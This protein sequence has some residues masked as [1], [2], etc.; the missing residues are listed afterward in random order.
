MTGFSKQWLHIRNWEYV[1]LWLGASR[2]KWTCVKLTWCNLGTNKLWSFL[3]LTSM[4]MTNDLSFVCFFFFSN[5]DIESLKNQVDY[6]FKK[7][8][9]SIIYIFKTAF[10]VHLSTVCCVSLSLLQRLQSLIVRNCYRTYI[11]AKNIQ[12]LSILLKRKVC[13][14]MSVLD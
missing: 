10:V 7:P 9:V 11:A 2:M 5:F 8:F 4:V 13:L 6:R 1:W 14:F 12:T 3:Q